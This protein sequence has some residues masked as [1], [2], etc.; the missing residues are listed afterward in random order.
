[1][2]GKV[3]FT[4]PAFRVKAESTAIP[5]NCSLPVA[6]RRKKTW[7]KKGNRWNRDAELSG[8]AALTALSVLSAASY[9]A[10]R[11][12]QQRKS[13]MLRRREAVESGKPNH[14]KDKCTKEAENNR[15]R[16]AFSFDKSII[17]KQ[18]T[19]VI[20]PS[21]A[22]IRPATALMQAPKRA[23]NAKKDKKLR[24][25]RKTAKEAKKQA[26]REQLEQLEVVSSKAAASLGSTDDGHT[27]V[28]YVDFDKTLD[29][30][31]R[32]KAYEETGK[33]RYD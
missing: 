22:S 32:V 17:G 13:K 14:A 11:W 3:G 23:G 21:N 31:Q 6:S 8:V 16:S 7:K 24:N 9:V 25:E 18:Q 19:P 1:M 4:T 12:W 2:S 30:F 26:V 5:K 28:T 20:A 29:A 10:W 15:G 27:R 33:K